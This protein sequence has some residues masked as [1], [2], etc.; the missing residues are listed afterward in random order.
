VFGVLFYSTETQTSIKGD[1]TLYNRIF[2]ISDSNESIVPILDQWVQQG[3]NVDLY[4]FR[5]LIKQ[6]KSS[7]RFQHALQMS[8][9]MSDQRNLDIIR[10]D[11][12]VKLDLITKVHGIEHAE[13]YFNDLP[14]K[15]KTFQI[16][17]VLLESYAHIKSVEK[18]EFHMEKMM[19]LG[20][21]KSLLVY[22][23]MLNLYSKVGE[24]EKMNTLLEKMDEKAVR[25]SKVTVNILLNAYATT[26]E[27]NEMEKT[28]QKME[29]F[30]DVEVDSLSYIIAANT[31][32]KAGLI[33]NALEMLKKSEEL[34]LSEK[35][36]SSFGFLLTM[37]AHLGRKED[38]HRIWNLYKSS[39]KVC[40]T[41]Y[42][43][44]V[45]S[46][47]K[48]NDI[49]GAEKIIEEWESGVNSYEFW[50]P[51][52]LLAA[53]CKNGLLEK[54]E[55]FVKNAME[56]GRKPYETTW[57][58]LATG[59]INAN[60]IPKAVEAIKEA[61]LVRRPSWKPKRDTLSACL[62]YLK[63]QGD[64]KETEEFVRIL[65][66]P[67]HTSTADCEGLLDSM[68]KEAEVEK[69]NEMDGDVWQLDP[70]KLKR[71]PKH[72]SL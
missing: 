23:I 10:S 48:L 65:G 63:Q 38:L 57:D 46:L 72:L 68:Y 70:L 71:R 60:Q 66:I 27:I 19:K 64:A 50:I 17:Y 7:K 18:A 42:R 56:N 33:G 51:N 36:W 44:M 69:V 2:S 25:P 30:P 61:L 20:F 31:Y 8:K 41:G 45:G 3:N 52:L 28:I 54:A 39:A 4:K 59:Y 55:I 62:V 32:I 13:K 5:S 40:N 12:V 14:K 37:Y 43:C 22:N 15:S 47:L 16:N 26:L 34:I 67:G 6:L 35:R 29:A 9:W 24:Y 11:Y 21:V 53:Y 49:V 58:I 1:N